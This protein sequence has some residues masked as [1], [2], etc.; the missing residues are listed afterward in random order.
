MLVAPEGAAGLAGV[1]RLLAEGWLTG[2]EQVVVINTGS[3]LTADLG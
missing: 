1:R 2:T 3:G